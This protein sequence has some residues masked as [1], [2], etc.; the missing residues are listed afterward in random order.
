[1]N[2]DRRRETAG[3]SAVF[4]LGIVKVQDAG[5]CRVRVA[6]PDRD[7][8]QSWWLPVIV[9]KAQNDKAYWIP[10]VGEQVV[11]LMDAH[12]EDG[13]VIGAIYSAA[14]ATPVQSSDAF[15]LSCKDGASFEYNRA[16]HTL[17]VSIPNGGT[18]TIA[19]NGA[20]ITIDSGGDVKV[21]ASGQIQLGGGALMG[22]ARLG[23]TVACPA[24]TGTIVSASTNVL[25]D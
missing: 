19:A 13:A 1:M 10:D 25:A 21:M 17:Q 22:V 16:S 9:P 4:R 24:G 7:Q 23:D 8:M 2:Y 3:Q 5:Q 18:V 12:D 14:D 6:F 15:H 20:R 11:C